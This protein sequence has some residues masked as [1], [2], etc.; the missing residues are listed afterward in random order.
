MKKNNRINNELFYNISP[1]NIKPGHLDFLL[2]VYK[3]CH[4]VKPIISG[5]GTA[6][7]KISAFVDFLQIKYMENN[8]IPL[9][10]SNT[11]HFLN[12]LQDLSAFP[13]KLSLS[14]WILNA[15]TQTYFIKMT[16]K[17]LD[18]S[19]INT[20]DPK[21]ADRISRCIKCIL[22][23]KNFTFNDLYYAYIKD[24]ENYLVIGA[25]IL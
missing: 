6:A 17:Q 7:K 3:T 15:Y 2:K 9:Y 1:F 4:P 16:L 11:T 12:H 14:Q 23:N 19:L 22:K 20:T 8:F 5:N 25:H 18:K 13:G 21:V 10:T 24:V